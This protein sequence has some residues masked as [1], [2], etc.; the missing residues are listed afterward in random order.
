[1]FNSL[2]GKSVNRSFR[3]NV[4]DKLANNSKFRELDKKLL[5]DKFVAYKKTAINAFGMF[6]SIYRLY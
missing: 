1:M 3:K 4:I 5:N 6:K 2:F